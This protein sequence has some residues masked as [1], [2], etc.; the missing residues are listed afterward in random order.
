MV[1]CSGVA[2]VKPLTG[3]NGPGAS[4]LRSAE[5]DLSVGC[6][7]ILALN[8]ELGFFLSARQTATRRHT[9]GQF[10]MAENFSE[11][12]ITKDQVRGTPD[13]QRQTL[14]IVIPKRSEESALGLLRT[15]LASF[16]TPYH[17]HPDADPELARGRQEGSPYI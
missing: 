8:F 2:V 15:A 10:T 17:C 13:V 14:T 5:E 1:A 3:P 16:A 9:K 12:Q 6:S 7:M 11:G 4:A